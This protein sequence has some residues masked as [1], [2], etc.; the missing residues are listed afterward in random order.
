MTRNLCNG[1]EKKSSYPSFSEK[2]RKQSSIELLDHLPANRSKE[3]RF[4]IAKESIAFDLKHNAPSN[5]K[6]APLDTAGM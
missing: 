6:N 3:K 1:K 2:K 4:K 5:P